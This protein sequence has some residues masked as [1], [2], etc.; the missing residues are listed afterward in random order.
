MNGVGGVCCG[1]CGLD[2]RRAGENLLL[3][4]GLGCGFWELFAET[5]DH[6]RVFRNIRRTR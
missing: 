5:T 3:F 6:C 4:G 1:E 2:R